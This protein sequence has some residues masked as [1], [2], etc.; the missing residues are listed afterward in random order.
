MLNDF[1]KAT[2]IVSG[3]RIPDNVFLAPEL[4]HYAALVF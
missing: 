3:A 2:N 4:F 1:F